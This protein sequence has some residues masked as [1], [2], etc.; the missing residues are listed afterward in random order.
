MTRRLK[1]ITLAIAGLWAVEA[2]RRAAFVHG[3]HYVTQQC[4]H[5]DQE[6]PTQQTLK[7]R[8]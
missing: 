8:E 7:K 6:E 4:E 3:A 5:V 2:P 1:R